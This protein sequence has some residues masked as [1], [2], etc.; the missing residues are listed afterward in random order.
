MGYKNIIKK[1][2]KYYCKK[3]E[4]ELDGL[5]YFTDAEIF[6]DVILDRIKGIPYLRYEIDEVHHDQGCYIC[7]NCSEDL[8]L[9]YNE[10]LKILSR[11]Q[12]NLYRKFYKENKTKKES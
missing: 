7:P 2:T 4:C 12:M 6:Y 11:I 9:D 1:G 3:C 8:E 5:M 10:A